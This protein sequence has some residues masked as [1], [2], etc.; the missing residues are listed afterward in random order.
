MD[1]PVDVRF[2]RRAF[3]S[4]AERKRIMR[5]ERRRFLAQIK[6]MEAQSKPTSVP[7]LRLVERA[8]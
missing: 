4:H 1:E 8:A 5:R 3:G 6:A 2:V 7:H